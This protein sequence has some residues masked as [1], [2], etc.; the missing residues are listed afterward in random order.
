MIEHFGSANVTTTDPAIVAQWKSEIE[1][2]AHMDNIVCFQLGGVMHAFNGN[3]VDTRA[4][5]RFVM[6]AVSAFG[7]DRLCYEVSVS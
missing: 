3:P 7:Y 1:A 2:L 6:A 5:E 4:L